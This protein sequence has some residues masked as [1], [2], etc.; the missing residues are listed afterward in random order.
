LSETD[1]S[2]KEAERVSDNAAEYCPS[3][4]NSAEKNLQLDTV[5]ESSEVPESS[6][7]GSDKKR[8]IALEI[9]PVEL[10]SNTKD[11]RSKNIGNTMKAE[12]ENAENGRPSA[13]SPPPPSLVYGSG[14]PARLPP[15]PWS[16]GGTETSLE[17]DL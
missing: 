16:T 14:R 10:N 6:A 3:F 4:L 13:D 9:L 12:E 11:T 5:D 15:A 8:T 7:T 17:R 1:S 2:F